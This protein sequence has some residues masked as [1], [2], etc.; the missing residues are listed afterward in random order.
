MLAVGTSLSYYVGGGHFWPKA[1]KIQLDDAPRGLRD[2]LKAADLYVKSDALVG[3]EAILAGLDK[4]LGAGKPTAAAIRT[5]ELAHRIAT[6]PADSMEFPVEPGVLD[7]RKVIT[8]LDAVIPKDWDIVV[9]GGHQAYFNAQMRGRPAERYT[10]VR[11]FGAVGNGLCYALGV[12]AARRQ[13]RQGKVVLFEGDGGLMFHIQELETLKRQGYRILICAM[14][15][16]GYGSEFHKLRADGL[17]DRWAI[18]GR[19]A[20]ENIARGFGLRGNEIRDVSVI[21][22]LFNDFTA[23]G[24]SEI[25]NIQISDQITAPVMRQTVKRGHGN[26]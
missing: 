9:G 7:P 19:P 17:D 11:E 24:E 26:M 13:G 25:W 12:A 21:P 18:F 10:T 1:Y 15:D 14:N 8:A 23:Q 2:G 5:K 4:K 3:T 6:E 20:F 16:G 22:K